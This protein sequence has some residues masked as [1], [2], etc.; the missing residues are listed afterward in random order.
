MNGQRKRMRG[1][2]SSD[3]LAGELV[4]PR[5]L[6]ALYMY[7]VCL[8]MYYNMLKMYDIMYVLMYEMYM[9]MFKVKCSYM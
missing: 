8:K 9:Y 1:H 7:F 4:A 3:I 2:Q 6:I 5:V